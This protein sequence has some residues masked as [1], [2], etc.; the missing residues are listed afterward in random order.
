V[1]VEGADLQALQGMRRIIERACPRLIVVEADDA[2]LTRF[3]DSVASLTQ[4]L[5]ALGYRGQ[6]I[7]EEWHA[8]SLAFSL[9]PSSKR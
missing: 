4:Y 5:D 3:G 1:D 2:M 7:Q 9:I 8:P 6:P